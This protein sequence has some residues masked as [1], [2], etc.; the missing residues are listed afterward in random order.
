LKLAAILEVLPGPVNQ[1]LRQVIWRI[2]S[3]GQAP[4]NASSS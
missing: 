3:L 2:D 4:E 1:G